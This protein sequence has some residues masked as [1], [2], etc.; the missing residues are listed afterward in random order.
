MHVHLAKRKTANETLIAIQD[1]VRKYVAIK[2]LQFGGLEQV[3]YTW[4]QMEDPGQDISHALCHVA[5]ETP[6][7]A[8]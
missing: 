5:L 3:I 1:P 2:G 4:H 7:T 8:I 6:R